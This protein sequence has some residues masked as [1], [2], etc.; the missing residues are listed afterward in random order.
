MI[1]ILATE[2]LEES[3]WCCLFCGSSPFPSSALKISFY[4]L[5]LTPYNLESTPILTS[6]SR[7]SKTTYVSQ[8]L[9]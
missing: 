4:F 3:K 5:Y 7:N 1:D 2:V 8:R 6:N 9:P